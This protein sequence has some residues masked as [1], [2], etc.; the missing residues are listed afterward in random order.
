MERRKDGWKDG[1]MEVKAGL[2]IAYSNQKQDSGKY[3]HKANSA[4]VSLSLFKIQAKFQASRKFCLKMNTVGNE[5]FACETL[6][7]FLPGS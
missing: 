2:R 7:Y 1:W 3:C 4:I 6:A 5:I